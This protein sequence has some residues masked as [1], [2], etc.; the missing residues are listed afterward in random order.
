MIFMLKV[1]PDRR[2]VLMFLAFGVRHDPGDYGAQPSINSPTS[3]CAASRQGSE[4]G[5]GA[6]LAATS[7]TRL[8]VMATSQVFS[9]QNW[10]LAELS[11]TPSTS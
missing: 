1:Q 3:G 10:R 7:A 2:P 9:E 8:R 11:A 6:Q 4:H 5:D